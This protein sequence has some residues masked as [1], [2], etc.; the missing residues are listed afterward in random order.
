MLQPKPALLRHWVMHHGGLMATKQMGRGIV[1]ACQGG[2]SHTASRLVC[3]RNCWPM[4]IGI[5]GR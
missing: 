1:L 5:S 4:M 2:G 3:L